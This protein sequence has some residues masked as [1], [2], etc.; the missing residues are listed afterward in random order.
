MPSGLK[1]IPESLLARLW[2]ER[3]SREEALRAGDGR[4]F[5][6]IYPGREGTSAGPDFRQVV[7]EEEGV[8][9]VTGDIEVH[10]R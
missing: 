3:A 2:K 5:R 1:Q 6:V 4:R 7:L 9:L 10:V 8:G